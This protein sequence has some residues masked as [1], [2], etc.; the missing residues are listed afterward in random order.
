MS[1]ATWGL[2]AAAAVLGFWMV[3]AYNRLVRLRNAVGEAFASLA[4]QLL[5]RHDLTAALALAARSRLDAGPGSH[6]AE[7][8]L[9]EAVAAAA[10]Q[11]RAATAA[12]QARPTDADALKSLSMAEQ[13]LANALSRVE[14]VDAPADAAS[15][16]SDE[17][18]Q[19]RERWAQ[20]SATRAQLA[21]AAQLFNRA[22]EDY[23]S[24]ARQFP[25][26]IVAALFAFRPAAALRAAPPA[27]A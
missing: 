16:Y 27:D 7:R 13:V 18:T 21:F 23:N 19:E 20:L 24:A 17:A 2:L 5:H 12:A 4:P 9:Y 15:A 8:S 11:A 22:V 6:E 14:P 1:G 10:N 3:G 26:R 25:T